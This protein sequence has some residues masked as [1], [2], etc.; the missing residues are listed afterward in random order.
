MFYRRLS[1]WLP[2]YTEKIE[3]L[4]MYV[5]LKKDPKEFAGFIIFLAILIAI[6]A[7]FI[8]FFIFSWIYAIPSS[9]AAFFIVLES[10]DLAL[11]LQADKRA[12]NAEE[13][14]P[15]ALQLMA[16]NLRAGLT[17][18]KALLVSARE[19]FGVLNEEFKRVAKEIATGRDITESLL[20]MSKRIKSPLIERTIQLIIFGIVSGGELASLLEESAASLR[21]Q[22]ITQK[23]IY[24][25]I[26]M[27]TIFIIV[28]VGFIAPLLFGLSSV[29]VETMQTTL[30]SVEAP[31]PEVTSQVPLS[32]SPVNVNINFVMIF[33][34]ILLLVSS[35]LS[36]FVLGLITKGEEKA[37]LK[38]IPL[39]AGCALVVFFVVR[40]GIV[41]ILATFF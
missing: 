23:Q 8:I 10:F 14:L 27:Y 30:S 32:I 1:A 6:A 22:Y 3:K 35:V 37:G 21:Q 26:L 13:S 33:S 9:V 18:D 11:N 28:A 4:S 7:F 31:P 15:D 34:I 19:E 29:L 5:A 17:T 40:L 20:A 39:L 25:S 41:K 36:S 12:K 24:A 16:T 38:Y 2:R